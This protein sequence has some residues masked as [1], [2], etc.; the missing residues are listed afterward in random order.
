MEIIANLRGR[1]REEV[2]YQAKLWLAKDSTYEQSAICGNSA[3]IWT[4]NIYTL[5]N[6]TMELPEAIKT[7]LETLG[8]FTEPEQNQI[9]KAIREQ[10]IAQREEAIKDLEAKTEALKD[11]LSNM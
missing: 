6:K 7:T 2:E 9:I 1:S 11:S 5:K 8:Q 4:A 3:N 10:I